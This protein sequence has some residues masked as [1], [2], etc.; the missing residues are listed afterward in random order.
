VFPIR[1]RLFVNDTAQLNFT[2]VPSAEAHRRMLSQRGEPLF[3]AAWLNVL[4]IHF[5]VNAAALQRDVPFELDLRDGRAFVSLVAFTMRGMKPRFGGKLMALLFHPIATHHFL[6]IRTYVRHGGEC[7]IH[8]IAEWLTNRLAVILGP[9]TFGL[10]YRYGR[11]SYRVDLENPG[12]SGHLADP[13][14]RTTLT[15]EA[16]LMAPALE[17]S[18]HPY[19]L[20]SHL[21]GAEKEQLT[22]TNGRGGGGER[23]PISGLNTR[24]FLEETLSFQPCAAG[25]LDEWLMERYVAFNSANG[26][27]RF[28]RVWHPPWPQAPAKAVLGEKSLLIQNWP[29]L[30]E[31]RPVGANFSPGFKTVWMGRPNKVP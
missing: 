22:G 10:P 27:R 14:S 8:F 18:P 24:N 12:F 11:I 13:N 31:A 6:N 15:F 26:T 17:P 3:V 21:M 20:S 1:K 28:F 29:W 30:K 7:G 19:P 25:S 2:R 4:M 16:R 5:E 9:R 23:L